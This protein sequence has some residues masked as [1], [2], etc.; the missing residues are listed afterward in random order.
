MS[1]FDFLTK[2]NILDS[3]YLGPTIS[4]KNNIQNKSSDCFDKDKL[5]NAEG[6]N[7]PYKN[8]LVEL[9]HFSPEL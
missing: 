3:M 9:L 8:Y 4:N 5:Y 2:D 6:P 7:T 1:Q